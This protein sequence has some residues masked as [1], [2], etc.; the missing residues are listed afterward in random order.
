MRLASIGCERPEIFFDSQPIVNL[1][2]PDAHFYD[3]EELT[4]ARLLRR[5]RDFTYH[6]T[7]T[8]NRTTDRFANLDSLC[9]INRRGRFCDF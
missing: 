7:N 4:S 8:D 3:T 9:A 6:W 1:R 5:S 2:I